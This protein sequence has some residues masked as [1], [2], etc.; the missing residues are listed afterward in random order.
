MIAT[1]DKSN[2]GFLIGKIKQIQGRVFEKMLTEEGIDEFN[3]AQGRILYVLWHDDDITISTLS[4]RT[5]LAKTTLTSMLDRIEKSGYIKRV[6]APNDRRAIKIVLT[7]KARGIKDRYDRVSAK[8]T[9]LF[10]IGFSDDEIVT[11]E[12]NLK[13][14]L[15]NLTNEEK[16]EA[17]L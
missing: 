11:F 9:E 15:D 1:V 4:A 10:Y 3:G 14:V 6:S 8:M 2:G 13:R 7:D 16:K 17:F 12:A 5:G